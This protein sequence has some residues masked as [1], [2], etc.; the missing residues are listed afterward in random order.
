MKLTMRW[1]VLVL[2]ALVPV[3]AVV[4][5]GWRFNSD[6]ERAQAHA[7]QGGV[8]LQTRCESESDANDL[9]ALA[10]KMTARRGRFQS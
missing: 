7:V 1:S 4:L 6:M 3:G 2:L 10:T 9:V 8:L 5:I